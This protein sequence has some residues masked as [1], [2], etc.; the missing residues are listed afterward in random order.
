MNFT[1]QHKRISGVLTVLPHNEIK[2]EDEMNQYNFPLENTLRLKQIMGYDRH[3]IAEPGVC[4]SDLCIF[5]LRSLLVRGLVNKNDIDALILVTQTPDYLLPPTSNTIQGRLGLK[6]DIF[7]LDI[8]QGCAG[9]II[10]L[11]QAFMLLE[12]DAVKKAVVLNGDILS[13]KTSC[14]DRNSYPLIGDGAAVTI[15]EKT[16]QDNTIYAN[17]KMDGSRGEALMIP[18]GGLRMPVTA[19][20][21]VLEDDGDGN[22]RSKENLVMDGLGIFQF[23]QTEVPQMVDNLLNFSGEDKDKVDYFMFH[24][25]NRFML[26]KLADQMQVPRRKMPSNIVERFGN[27]SGVTIPANITFN[28]GSQLRKDWLRLCLSGFGTGLAWGSM[29]L[30]VGG[31]DFC[32]MIDYE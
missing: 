2:F 32:E 29:L 22:L 27:A 8:N 18:A 28:L 3:R 23:V 30:T 21:R 25:P 1:F 9:Y 14:R 10:G 4:V 24:Q 13:R 16:D 20:T 11:I 5:G 7:C 17:I 31:L 26:E 6:Q 12:Q 19:E 15:V